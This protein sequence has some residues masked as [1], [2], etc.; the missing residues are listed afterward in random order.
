[1]RIELE[2][3]EGGK[4]TFAQTYAPVELRL[5]DSRVSLL[6]GPA[7]SGKIRQNGAKV[8]VTG[9][10]TARAQL[11]CDRCL[12]P[13]EL[14]IDSTF[15]LDYVT[16]EEYQAQQAVELT[17]A[18]LDLSVFDG[19]EIDIDELVMEELLLAVPDHILCSES[20]KGICAIC[21]LDKNSSACACET[22][23]IDPRWA[24]LKKL[25]NGKS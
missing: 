12:K 25:V 9:R 20:C 7:V 13:I 2:S 3:L 4:G 16:A 23:T 17:E 14:L 22:G 15:E 19:V 18:D 11:E 21:G 1:M 8:T 24:E 10:T 5:N 6:E